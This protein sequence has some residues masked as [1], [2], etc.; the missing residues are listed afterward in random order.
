MSERIPRAV[1]TS[2]SQACPFHSSLF[3]ST[4]DQGKDT[5]TLQALDYTAP[6][7]ICP[8]LFS[9]S[10]WGCRVGPHARPSELGASCTCVLHYQG[11]LQKRDKGKEE[12]AMGGTAVRTQRE[13][14]ESRSPRPLCLAASL[15]SNKGLVVKTSIQLR[16]NTERSCV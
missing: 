8:D 7:W 13:V 6:R 4:R 9:A 3:H 5:D 2:C 15:T 14:R 1:A 10:E 16:N 12:P 11:P